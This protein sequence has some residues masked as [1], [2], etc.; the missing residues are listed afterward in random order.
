MAPSPISP[1]PVIGPIDVSGGTGNWTSSGQAVA[2]GP[3][4]G[5]VG[6]SFSG[7]HCI[8]EQELTLS[9]FRYPTFQ[10]QSLSPQDV[11]LSSTF[12]ASNVFSGS[13]INT[14]LGVRVAASVKVVKS[15][16]TFSTSS[17][18][19]PQKF[20]ALA[21]SADALGN[22]YGVVPQGALGP[23][24]QIITS[25]KFLNRRPWETTDTEVSEQA[26]GYS[27]VFHPSATP[28]G[29]G[30]TTMVG[31][32]DQHDMFGK[33]WLMD[34]RLRA[35]FPGISDWPY[36]DRYITNINWIGHLGGPFKSPNDSDSYVTALLDDNGLKC[37]T[38]RFLYNPDIAV[39]GTILQAQGELSVSSS[40]YCPSYTT[41]RHDYS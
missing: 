2:S 40:N 8:E 11:S 27:M 16:D 35:D 18:Q 19:Q 24:G 10:T 6:G 15:Y 38:G 20:Q 1:T 33:F 39:G 21:A 41:S 17:F 30:P 7:P 4:A 31:F 12:P 25:Q 13:V 5:S 36:H 26:N 23:A 9:Y 37:S 34:T 29:Y 22:T 32:A 14:K 28:T 3:P